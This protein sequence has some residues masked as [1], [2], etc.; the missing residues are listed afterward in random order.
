MIHRSR[1]STCPVGITTRVAAGSY[2]RFP[3]PDGGPD[4][5]G[6]SIRAKLQ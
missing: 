3:A 2:E 6:L 1:A 4:P 5:V